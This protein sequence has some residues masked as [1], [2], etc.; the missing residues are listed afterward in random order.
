MT[1]LTQDLR[2]LGVR[3]GDLVMLHASLRKLGL[4]RS[5]G[6]S[7]GSDLLLNAVEEAVG[8]AGTVLMVL[9]TDYPMDW[10][11]LKPVEQRAALLAGTP[12]FDFLNAPVLPEVG[13]LAEAFRR[14]PGT[15]VSQNPSGRFGARGRKAEALLRD[16][17]WN[18]YYGPGSPLH[19]LCEWGGRILRLGAQPD[20]VTALHYAEY[21]ANMPVKSRTRWD[22]VIE[23]SEG[24]RHVW[25]EC[26]NDSEGI[27]SWDG[28]DYFAQI[29]KEYLATQPALCGRVGDAEAELLDAAHL[30]HF[31]AKWMERHLTSR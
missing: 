5:Q 23:G 12:C 16:Q 20:T 2:A 25:T 13:Y 9:G 7:E 11:N 26:L 24:P 10:I 17:P 27:A 22:Y 19:R 6:V 4:A 30:V 28:D 14:R 15:L 21:V 1:N 3:P 29:L 8:E 18:D 31:G